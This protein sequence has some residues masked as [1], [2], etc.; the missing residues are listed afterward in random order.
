MNYVKIIFACS[1]IIAPLLGSSN[2]ESLEQLAEQIEANSWKHAKCATTAMWISDSTDFSCDS[3]EAY[4]T[5]KKEDRNR[6]F[7]IVQKLR[8]HP[9]ADK[10]FHTVADAFTENTIESTIQGVFYHDHDNDLNEKTGCSANALR[11]L[12]KTI[13]KK[14]VRKWGE[15][16]TVTSFTETRFN[17]EFNITMNDLFKIYDDCRASGFTNWK[18]SSKK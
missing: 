14:T 9:D 2:N 18:P 15:S 8:N 11:Y 12:S 5:C 6:H 16:G 13:D 10:P 7:A 1:F 3:L 17:P 4:D